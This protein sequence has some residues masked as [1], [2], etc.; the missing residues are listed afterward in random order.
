MKILNSDTAHITIKMEKGET[1]VDMIG[2]NKV[3]TIT[4]LEGAK[5]IC[6]GAFKYCPNVKLIYLPKS[7]TYIGDKIFKSDYSEVKIIYDGTSDDFQKIDYKREVYIPG[8]YDRYPYYSDYGASSDD[9]RFYRRYDNVLMWCEVYCK[10]DGKTL[11]FG[12]KE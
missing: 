1:N 2:G 6:N 7:I 12:N 3:E 9:E 5:K 10:K 4:I 11:T 8:K